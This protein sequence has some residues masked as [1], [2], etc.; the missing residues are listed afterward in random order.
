MAYWTTC[1]TSDCQ[2]HNGPFDK[3]Y[4]HFGMANEYDTVRRN[5]LLGQ[6]PM[7]DIQERVVI[8]FTIKGSVYCFVCK[9]FAPKN[10]SHFVTRE[11]FSDWRNAIVIM[12][13]I[14]LFETLC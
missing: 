5:I 8:V 7:S 9:L 4:R 3:S 6:K 1:G 10:I 2:H 11:G 13:E 12:K 14:L